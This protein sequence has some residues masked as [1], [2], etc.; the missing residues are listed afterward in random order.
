MKPTQ[1][2]VWAVTA[3]QATEVRKYQG[4][5]P[6]Q[7]QSAIAKK[8]SLS[9]YTVLKIMGNRLHPDP[10]FKPPQRYNPVASRQQALAAQMRQYTREHPQQSAA[11]V[12]RVFGVNRVTA[13][14]ILT[15]QVHPEAGQYRLPTA[16]ERTALLRRRNRQILNLHRAGWQV[17]EIAALH[18]LSPTYTSIL[19]TR[20]R[21]RQEASAYYL[22]DDAAN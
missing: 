10:D 22:M 8:F 17:K 19:L 13:R 2:R 15:H 18:E 3:L 20:E 9:R 12:G 1:D 4:K 16:T 6:G 11:Q 5:N 21:R 14:K 7:T